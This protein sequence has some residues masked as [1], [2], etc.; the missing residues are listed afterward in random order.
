MYSILR[1]SVASALT[2]LLAACGG[3]GGG[4]GGGAGINSTPTPVPPPPAPTISTPV[5]RPQV[6]NVDTAEYRESNA[7]RLSNAQVAWA[8]GATG[9]GIRIGFIDT[10]LNPDLP[11]LAANLDGASRDVASNRPMSD[12]FG[13]GTAV[14]SIAAGVRNDSGLMGVAFGATIIM[15][16]ADDPGT[17]PHSCRF[18]GE[19]S[20]AGIDAA[21]MAGARVIN[22]SIG[23]NGSDDLFDAVRRA[24]NAG[25]I[26]VVAAGNGSSAS[27]SVLAQQIGTIGA[28]RAIIVGALGAG[29]TNTETSDYNAL[30]SYS[31]RAG[32]SRNHYL[33]AP[34]Y[35][36]HG[37][38]ANGGIDWLSGTSFSAP[39]VTGAIALL[40]EAFPTLT[41]AQVVELLMI[42]ADDLG[43]EGNDATY[44]HGRLNIGRAFQPVG[45]A[46]LAG[47]AME[48]SAAGG[49]LPAA[50]GDAATRMDLETVVL[51]SFSR[52]FKVN[53]A[54]AFSQR[55]VDLLIGKSVTSRERSSQVDTST[56]SIALT[57]DRNSNF[58]S[59]AST[60]L[61]AEK[62]RLQSLSMMVKLDSRHSAAFGMSI[63]ASSLD[64]WLSD[65]TPRVGFV[66]GNPDTANG[67]NGVSRFAGALRRT[68]GGAGLTLSGE[69]GT[70][71]VA[72][73]SAT[74]EGYRMTS[75]A[76]DG[77]IGKASGSASFSQLDEKRSVLGARLGPLFNTPGSRTR[78]LTLRVARPFGNWTAS[79]TGRAGWSSLASGRLGSSAWSAEVSRRGLFYSDD[80]IS[81]QLAQPL[82]IENGGVWVNLPVTHD[83]ASGTTRFDRK[84]LNFSPSGREVAAE[85][86]YS[87]KFGRALVRANVFARQQPGHVRSADADFG[88]LLNTSLE[89]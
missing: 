8:Q 89:F 74:P 26:V 44:G 61:E 76:L 71:Q 25:I 48:I 54:S 9:A 50:A 28:G 21:R 72:A 22:L 35:L 85:L 16:R 60:E 1:T 57:A 19:D 29:G 46:K 11:D 17:C 2:L 83:Y 63:N 31:N 73:D 15:M 18:E 14:A 13:H 10:G 23:G 51:D 55:G 86:A 65:Q 34:G 67:F 3:G 68:A 78:F 7:A 39:V 88:G 81:F 38:M 42:S 56:F 66:S 70:I 30:V 5:T 80:L 40:L 82:R 43:Q 64:R 59:T 33:A 58:R 47:T 75:I 84:T 49:T 52:A 45:T 24:V 87:G 37:L 36:I 79:V 12:L 69:E 53:A 77:Q 32:L 27:P 4:S 20:A 62:A 41:A 6:V